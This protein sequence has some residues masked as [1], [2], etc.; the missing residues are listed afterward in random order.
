[1]S[2]LSVI[3]ISPPVRF[4]LLYTTTPLTNIITFRINNPFLYLECLS[5]SY[6]KQTLKT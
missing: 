5:F 6:I 3:T 1:M 2:S 4:T